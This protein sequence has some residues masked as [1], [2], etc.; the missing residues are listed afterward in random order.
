MVLIDQKKGYMKDKIVVIGGGG[1]AK[2]I[3]STIKKLDQYEILGYT[4]LINKGLVLGT[5]FL[6]TDEVLTDILKEHKNCKAVIG[7][8]SVEISDKRQKIYQMLKE[9]G[10]ELP[11]I[12]S[13]SA[14]VNEEVSL[15]EGT[16]IMEQTVIHPCSTIGKCVII[17][18]GTLIGH[19]CKVGDFV[20]MAGGATLAGGVEIGYN[21]I[22]GMGAKVI[23]YKKIGK[24]CLIAA[25]S[26]I[27]KDAMK[28]G[29]YFGVPAT[30]IPAKKV[31]G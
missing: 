30:E 22:I 25:G 18:S 11:V 2:V 8:G 9:I 20:H 6:G 12:I 23:Q 24:N 28:E 7:I 4:D 5:R 1:H 15:D 19:D 27:I 31:S 17:N 26:V 16:V 3:I 10:F 13:T 21:S 14:V 29:T